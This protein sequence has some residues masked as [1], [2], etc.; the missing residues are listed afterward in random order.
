F[1]V[2]DIQIADLQN[3]QTVSEILRKIKEVESKNKA[4]KK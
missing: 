4:L 2:F 1:K 3:E